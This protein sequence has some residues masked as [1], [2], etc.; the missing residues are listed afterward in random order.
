MR[1]LFFKVKII[2]ITLAKNNLFEVRILV[3]SSN[4]KLIPVANEISSFR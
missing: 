2:H 4:I 3:F 1:M